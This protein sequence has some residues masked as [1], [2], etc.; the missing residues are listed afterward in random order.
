MESTPATLLRR[1]RAE[2][3]LSQRALSRRAGTAQSVVA[4][5]ELGQTSP[6]W[7]TLCRL[8]AAAGFELQARLVAAPAPPPMAE[9][10]G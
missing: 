7:D 10:M 9:S 8:L 4:R 5:I 2:A 6:S 1:A 3:H